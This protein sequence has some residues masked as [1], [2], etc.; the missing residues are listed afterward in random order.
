M[1]GD[2][3]W[4]DDDF[5]PWHI[6]RVIFTIIIVVTVLSF[7]FNFASGRM[8]IFSTDWFWQLFGLFVTIWVISWIFRSWHYGYFGHEHEMRIL[9]RR[10]ARG[11]ISETEFKRK[12]KILRESHKNES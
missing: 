3:R 2:D 7:V 4:R 6:F 10:L 5:W 12:M 9:R 1:T 8:M 11:D